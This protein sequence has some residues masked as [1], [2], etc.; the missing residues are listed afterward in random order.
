MTQRADCWAR[1]EV[2]S[3]EEVYI[4]IPFNSEEMDRWWSCRLSPMGV[5]HDSRRRSLKFLNLALPK[6]RKGSFDGLMNTSRDVSEDSTWTADGP[7]DKTCRYWKARR[8]RV[9]CRDGRL[10]GVDG[11]SRRRV[12]CFAS[13]NQCRSDDTGRS[14]GGVLQPSC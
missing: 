4:C 6:L 8:D 5:V 10:M 1:D 14:T 12:S 11:N 3:R 9:A 13:V 7:M 2:I